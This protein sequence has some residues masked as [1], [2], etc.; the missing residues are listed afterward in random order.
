[1]NDTYNKSLFTPEGKDKFIREFVSVEMPD[2]NDNEVVKYNIYNLY[3]RIY[4]DSRSFLTLLDNKHYYEAFIIAGYM[5]E[6]CAVLS[7]IKDQ[8]PE[9]QIINHNKYFAKSALGRLLAILEMDK[10]DLAKESARNSYVM[11]LRLFY[12][13]GASI[14]KD[15][16]SNNKT[17]AERHEEIANRIKFLSGSNAE[18]IKILRDSYKRPDPEGYVKAFSNKLE[19]IDGGDFAHSYMKYCDFKHSNILSPGF[20]S[21]DIEH[22]H[23]WSIDLVFMVLSYLQIFGLEP[24]GH[25]EQVK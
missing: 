24:Y 2:F 14:I 4:D 3:K 7:Y 12:P 16:K 9:K 8:T 17:P 18:K 22:I 10:S 5:L 13:V 19:N 1:M 6:T 25:K 11:V 21:E 15:D 23:D 20:V